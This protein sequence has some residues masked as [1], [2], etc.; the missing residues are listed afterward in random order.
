[1]ASSGPEGR[2]GELWP[3]G[4]GWRALARKAGASCGVPRTAL[5]THCPCPV[6]R[7]GHIGTKLLRASARA[8]ALQAVRLSCDGAQ[9]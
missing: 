1:M 4:Q 2:G 5:W 3:R 8:H 9:P 6:L 7:Y